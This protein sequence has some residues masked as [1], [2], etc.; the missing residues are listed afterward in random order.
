MISFIVLIS[1]GN[2]TAAKDGFSLHPGAG[3]Q[4]RSSPPQGYIEGGKRET[5]LV[6]TGEG[7][8]S[9]ALAGAIGKV[10]IRNANRGVSVRQLGRSGVTLV[11][12]GWVE[13]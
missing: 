9:Q 7:S 8:H 5:E 4:G 6:R 12:M 2:K 11:T 10:L 13:G 3:C 1:P